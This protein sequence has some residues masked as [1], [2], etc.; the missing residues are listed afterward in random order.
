[1]IHLN[2]EAQ[3]EQYADANEHDACQEMKTQP[4]ND[5]ERKEVLYTRQW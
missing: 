3:A 4:T 5:A 1:M 2:A